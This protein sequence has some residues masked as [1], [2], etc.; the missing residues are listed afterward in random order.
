LKELTAYYAFMNKSTLTGKMC[1]DNFFQRKITSP[2]KTIA[3][4]KN[5]KII[6]YTKKIKKILNKR[7]KI[8]Q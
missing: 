3:H 1:F 8:I 7:N 4:I 2:A 5:I 6:A